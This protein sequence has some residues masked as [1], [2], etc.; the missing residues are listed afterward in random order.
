M[1]IV[2]PTIPAKPRAPLAVH[3]SKWRVSSFQMESFAPAPDPPTTYEEQLELL[4]ARLLVIEDE[5]FAKHCLV[6]C[7]YYRLIAYRGPIYDRGAERFTDGATFNRLWDFYTFDRDLRRLL[8][9]GSK[10]LEISV[11]A[12]WSYVLAHEDGPQAFEN[13]DIHKESRDPTKDWHGDLLK[14]LDD[15]LT[16]CEDGSRHRAK[17]EAGGQRRPPIWACSEAMSFGLLSAFVGLLGP[18]ALKKRIAEPYGLSPDIFTPLVYQISV[19]RNLCAHHVRIWDRPLTVTLTLPAVAGPADMVGSL[20]RE[21]QKRLYN[22]FVMMTHVERTI[23]PSSTWPKRLV[24][25]IETQKFDAPDM[26]GF[27]KQWQKLPIWEPYVTPPE[28]Q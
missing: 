16:Q 4:K 13:R 22:T 11:R 10:G 7:N 6:H 28:K 18:Y 25:L 3:C 12:T 23:N 19:L 15:D 27:P 8:L 1:T 14:R 26:L 9:E 21:I 20:N 17:G 2:C 24:R 5:A